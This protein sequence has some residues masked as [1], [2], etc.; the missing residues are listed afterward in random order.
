MPTIVGEHSPCGYSVS[1]TWTFDGIENKNDLYRGEDCMK[2]FCESLGEDAKKTINSEKT[3]M[4]PLTNEQQES[5][6]KTKIF[7]TCKKSSNINTLMIKPIAKL[8]TIFI[9]LVN[10]EVLHIA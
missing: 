10:T 5:Y 3:K 8:G 4:I 1:T 6:E 7:Y 9:T 2:K